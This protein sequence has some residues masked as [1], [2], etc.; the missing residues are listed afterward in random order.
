MQAQDPILTVLEETRTTGVYGIGMRVDMKPPH[1]VQDIAKMLDP[2]GN[3]ILHTVKVGDLLRGVDGVEVGKR[4]SIQPLES[5][6]PGENGTTAQ[7]TFHSR[8]MHS[9]Y[10]VLV[11]R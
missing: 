5:L 9:T 11:R 2:A 8:E 6:I 3:P 7:L 4:D 1:T 10:T